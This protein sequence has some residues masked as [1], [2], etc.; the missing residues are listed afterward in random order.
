MKVLVVDDDPQIVRALRINLEAR[1]RASSRPRPPP[2][3]SSPRAREAPDVVLLDL[4]LPDRDGIDV[5]HG[6]RRWERR[7]HLVLSGRAGGPDKV[8]ALDAG[9]DDYITK[10]PAWRNSSPASAPSPA[11][12]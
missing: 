3:P 10:P 5:I 9:A 7:A 12:R 11:E 1:G 2:R 8:A 4:G 6:I